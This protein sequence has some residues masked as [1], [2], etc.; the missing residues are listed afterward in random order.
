M[1]FGHRAGS[2]TLARKKNTSDRKDISAN[3]SPNP[4]FNSNS[5]SDTNP[6]FNSSSNPNLTL[7]HNNIFE[8]TK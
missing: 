7:N 1:S 4:N 6:K 5:N 3:S 8:L 2:T